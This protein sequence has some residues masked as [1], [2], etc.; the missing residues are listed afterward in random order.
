VLDGHRLSGIIVFCVCLV[1]LL[2]PLPLSNVPAA[3]II[4]LT[5]LAYLEHD[6][7]L[8]VIAQTAGIAMLALVSVAFLETFYG[9]SL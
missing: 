2:V 7:L 6:G 1:S 9:V 5:A 8:L 4:V 3:A